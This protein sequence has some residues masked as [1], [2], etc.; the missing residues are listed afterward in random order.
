MKR[1]PTPCPGFFT[2]LLV[3]LRVRKRGRNGTAAAGRKAAGRHEKRSLSRLSRLSWRGCGRDSLDQKR[4]HDEVDKL[5]AL[6]TF[7][8]YKIHD[9]RQHLPLLKGVCPLSHA[10]PRRRP[11]P[12]PRHRAG[13]ADF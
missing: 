13:R 10:F 12:P 9:L 11:P 8:P 7:D 6:P 3:I 5:H 1:R 2:R 4:L